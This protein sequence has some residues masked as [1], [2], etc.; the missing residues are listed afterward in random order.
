LRITKTFSDNL[1]PPSLLAALLK[2]RSRQ[3]LKVANWQSGPFDKRQM[4]EKNPAADAENHW[5]GNFN[6]FIAKQG[7][8]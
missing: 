1:W 8:M 6:T 2:T 3:R 5:F 7:G 4:P